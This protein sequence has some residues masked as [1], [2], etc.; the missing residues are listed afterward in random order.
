MS[1]TKRVKIRSSTHANKTP[2]AL[3]NPELIDMYRDYFDART[4]IK[5]VAG[6]APLLQ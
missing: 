4:F 2:K 3:K 5:N 1:A 6:I